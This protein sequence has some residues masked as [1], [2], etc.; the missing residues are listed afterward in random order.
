MS[1]NHLP[2]ICCLTDWNC[3]QHQT[4]PLLC[5][6]TSID[7]TYRIIGKVKVKQSC[8]DMEWPREFQEVKVPRFHENGTGW[9]YVC[10]S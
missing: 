5:Y 8:L 3:R 10:Q 6:T 7:G 9:W 2:K 4:D 1:Y